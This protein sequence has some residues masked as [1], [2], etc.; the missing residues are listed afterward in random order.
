MDAPSTLLQLLLLLVWVPIVAIVHEAGHA[1]AAGPAGFR[2]T[3]FGIGRGRPIVRLQ[4][5]AGVVFHIGWLFFTGGACVAIPRSPESGPRAALFHGGGIAAQL[6]LGA[7]LLAV[8]E[9]AMATWLDAGGQLNLLVAAWNLL[10][11]RVGRVAS[12]GWWLVSRLTGGVMAPRRALFE[13][14]PAMQRV[15]EYEQRVGSRVGT[16]YGHRMLAWCDLLV[17]RVSTAQQRLSSGPPLSVAD[18]H[19]EAI[20][21]LIRAE[22]HLRAD[23]P[24]VALRTLESVRAL[25]GLSD[26]TLDLLSV[27]EARAWL[28]FDDLDR[29]Q[30]V[31]GRL[32]GVGGSIGRE[33]TTVALRLAV[34]RADHAAVHSLAPRLSKASTAGLFDP[35]AAADALGRAAALTPDDDQAARWHARAVG[36]TR[37]ALQHASAEDQPAVRAALD[38]ILAPD[39][40]AASA[41]STAS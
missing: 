26:E 23:H 25:P 4:L 37:A 24:L 36:L 1:L 34:A 15:L 6:V 41:A 38:A 22:A 29:A 18:P 11:W 21:G 16:W 40:M 17:G 39:A 9:G 27:V 32:A 35:L 3:S 14:R 30:S 20:D 13:Q 8:P 7:A 12:D 10:P 19:L 28:A 31:L 5:P 33:A 2:V